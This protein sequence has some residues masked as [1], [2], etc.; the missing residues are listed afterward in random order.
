MH[1]YIH[2][3]TYTY[4]R[5]DTQNVFSGV[6][7]IDHIPCNASRGGMLKSRSLPWAYD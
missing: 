6:E 3:W 7:V 1:A 4:T 5:R 2:A